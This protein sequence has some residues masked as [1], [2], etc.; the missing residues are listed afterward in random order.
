MPDGL[1]IDSRI[2]I[3][4]SF[5]LDPESTSRSCPQSDPRPTMM[6]PKITPYLGYP[7]LSSSIGSDSYPDFG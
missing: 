3:N 6:Q 5:S 1:W 2:A 4:P 7:I